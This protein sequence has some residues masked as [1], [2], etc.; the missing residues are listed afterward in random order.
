[1]VAERR[2][3]Q[4]K[5]ADDGSV[6]VADIGEIV[7]DR[8]KFVL[9]DARRLEPIEISKSVL[10]SKRVFDVVLSFILLVLSLPILIIG[11]IIVS[12]YKG[13]TTIL[14]DKRGGLNGKPFKHLVLNVYQSRNKPRSLML[15]FLKRC[16]LRLLPS[17]INVLKGDMSFV[18]PEPVTLRKLVSYG[19]YERQRLRVRPGLTCFWF[20]RKHANLGF[21]E[22]IPCDIGYL[23]KIGL[24][25]DFGILLRSI[26]VQA[27]RGSKATI[28]ERIKILGVKFFN[29]TMSDALSYVTIAARR[30]SRWTLS[31]INADCLN[32]SFR[33]PEYMEI[34]RKADA[35]FPDGIGIH[36]A[37]RILGVGLKENTNGT[38]FFPRL[39]REAARH[40]LRL[41]LLG[42]APGIAETAAESMRKIVPSVNIVGTHHGYLNDEDEKTV[43]A[44]INSLK[45]D[46][47][48]VGMGVPHQE[49]WISRNREKINAG[50]AMGVGGLFDFYS[51]KNARAPIWMREVGLE[52]VYRISQEPKRMWKRYVVGN[53]LFLYRVLRYG[54]ERP[55]VLNHTISSQ[56]EAKVRAAGTG[57]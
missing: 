35:V 48:M 57:A 6:A 56:A 41:Y 11:I 9:N 45:T 52:W 20:L 12:F 31:F 54:A 23:K 33:D 50:V 49:K 37:S 10:I 42:G 38:D 32:I 16:G 40:N 14:L 46:I 18:G 25:T 5:M 39:C 53:P 44:E 13:R 24:L 36:L 3:L 17:L 47:L 15:Q 27:I 22:Q 4:K 8:F 30:R 26:V 21:D 1:M 28:D 29:L 43:I 34:L 2:N 51:G 7:V 19:E 55:P